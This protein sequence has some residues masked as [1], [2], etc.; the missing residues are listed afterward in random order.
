MA[1]FDLDELE[2]KLE[3][4]FR[5]EASDEETALTAQIM[6]A[7]ALGRCAMHLWRIEEHLGAMPLGE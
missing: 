7:V 5:G 1:M 3:A 2:E 6:T 4:Q